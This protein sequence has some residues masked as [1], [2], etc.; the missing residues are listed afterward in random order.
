LRA[1]EPDGTL[2]R[3]AGEASSSCCTRRSTC[4]SS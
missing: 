2:D 3:L 4:Q 1:P